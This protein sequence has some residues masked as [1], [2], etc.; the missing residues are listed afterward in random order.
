[1]QM[2]F[3]EREEDAAKV[4]DF[5]QEETV[6]SKSETAAQ[7]AD[8]TLERSRQTLEVLLKADAVTNETLQELNAQGQTLKNAQEGIDTIQYQQEWSK[9]Y[10]RSIRSFFWTLLNKFIPEPERVDHTAN[11]PEPEPVP[12]PVDNTI[13][14]TKS[15][16]KTLF[17]RD[18]ILADNDAVKL[19][20]TNRQKAAETD[21][22]LAQMSSVLTGLQHKSLLMGEEIDRQNAQLKVLNK[23][24]E[25]ANDNFKD[26]NRKV[27]RL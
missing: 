8:D 12:V 22:N 4:E 27:A 15:G 13:S 24:T 21:K 6:A 9:R 5:E 25:N 11:I 26:L 1:M 7:L 14:I 17:A 23:T 16:V 20:Q 10:E 18:E 2:R 3:R 19:K